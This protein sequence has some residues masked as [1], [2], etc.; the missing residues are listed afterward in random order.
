MQRLDPVSR[1]PSE[2]IFG[3]N[4][5][6]TVASRER[7]ST[8]TLLIVSH[9]PQVLESRFHMY[10]PF[11]RL[12]SAVSCTGRDLTVLGSPVSCHLTDAAVVDG[13]TGSQQY[14]V[15]LLGMKD[16]RLVGMRIEHPINCNA[17]AVPRP[18]ERFEICLTGM[19]QLTALESFSPGYRS[20]LVFAGGS[21]GRLSA[22]LFH[23][24]SGFAPIQISDVD[25]LLQ[26]NGKF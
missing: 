15:G 9:D 25:D 1:S 26:P 4:V 16:S 24:K 13:S 6:Y 7:P 17:A 18:V 20:P 22:C 10:L 21:S 14:L 5:G 11:S 3:V 8:A 23:P 2:T 19:G 12:S